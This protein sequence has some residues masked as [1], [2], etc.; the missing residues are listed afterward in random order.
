[1]NT[2]PV[3]FLAEPP[4]RMQRVHVLIRLVLLIA[5]GTIGIS[6]LY[7]FLYL[8]LPALAALLISQHGAGRYLFQSAPRAVRALRWLAAAYAYLWLLTDD[9][10]GS[11][12]AHPIELYV[13]PGGAPTISSALLRI[14]FS[15]P[16]AILL[17]VLSFVGVL[18]WILGAFWILIAQHVPA[19]ISDYLAATLRYQFRLV[20]YHLSL[21]GRYPSLE[22]EH[23]AHDLPQSG[24]AQEAGIAA[25]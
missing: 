22:G 1:M 2:H 11:E 25:R 12:S 16:A 23:V 19:G 3:H 9:L 5:L 17:A 15:I 18:F 13:E 14:L 20:A 10:P 8:A 24:A 6:S 21:V 4:A 7:W